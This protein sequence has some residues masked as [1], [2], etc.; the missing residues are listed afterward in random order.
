MSNTGVSDPPLPGD[1]GSVQPRLLQPVRGR[2]E[3]GLLGNEDIDLGISL[4]QAGISEGDQFLC[5]LLAQAHQMP[6][7]VPGG[8]HAV[9]S[10]CLF[11]QRQRV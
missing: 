5:A 6:A 10:G 4:S 1:S 2:W 7:L 11:S 9:H 3:G 8:V